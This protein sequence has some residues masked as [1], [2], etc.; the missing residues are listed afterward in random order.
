MDSSTVVIREQEEELFKT[1]YFLNLVTVV[2][3]EGIYIRGSY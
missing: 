1:G 3:Y 2:V